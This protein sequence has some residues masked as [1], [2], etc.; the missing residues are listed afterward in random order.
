MERP[1]PEAGEVRTETGDVETGDLRTR[2]TGETGETGEAEAGEADRPAAVP[3]RRRG[4]TPALIA[5]AAALGVLAGGCVGYVVQAGRP[6]TQLPPLSQPVL[7][8]GKG[9]VPLLSAAEDRQVR[10]D[11]DLRE[12]LLPKP[13]GARDENIGDDGWMDLAEYATWNEHPGAG[14]RRAL[15]NQLRRVADANWRIGATYSVEIRL[16]QYHQEL[17]PSARDAVRD[18][19]GW[20]GSKPDVDSRPVPGAGDGMAFVSRR[21]R[22]APG[23]LPMYQ[24][25]AYASRGDIV[26]Q[27]WITDTRPVPE[28]KIMDLAKRQVSRL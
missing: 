28:K 5:A 7:R 27:M 24:A 3:S 23:Y 17:A 21:P 13:R 10:T 19:E 25:E 14:F 4:R 9:D 12:L 22:T 16:V 20:V 6:P 11:G 15:Q 26:M 18:Q 8:Q 1:E 2:E